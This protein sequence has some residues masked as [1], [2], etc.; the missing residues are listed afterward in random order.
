MNGRREEEEA[1]DDRLDH[2]GTGREINVIK[3]RS[4]K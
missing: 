4:R 3:K 1:G 2:L